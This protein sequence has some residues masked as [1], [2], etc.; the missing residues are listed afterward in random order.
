[1]VL[2]TSAAFCDSKL[3][4]IP[5][6]I[7]GGSDV[8][9]VVVVA[10]VVACKEGRWEECCDENE[11]DDTDSCCCCNCEFSFSSEYGVVCPAILKIGDS[12]LLKCICDV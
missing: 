6:G 7:T 11:D 1:M 3:P 5:A 2:S 10:V 4:P 9:V 8:A 12:L